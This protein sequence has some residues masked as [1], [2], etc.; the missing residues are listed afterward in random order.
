MF[1]VEFEFK[2]YD[3]VMVI[4][5]SSTFFCIYSQIWIEKPTENPTFSTGIAIEEIERVK[6]TLQLT[7]IKSVVMVILI[8]SQTWIEKLT[9]KPIFSTGIAIEEIEY[10]KKETLQCCL[11][12]IR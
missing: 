5:I 9:K 3:I 10:V 1:D 8:R 6:E 4:L 11:G 7:S 12:T 2:F